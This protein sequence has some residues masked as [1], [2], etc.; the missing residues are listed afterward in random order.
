MTSLSQLL[1][2]PATRRGWSVVLCALACACRSSTGPAAGGHPEGVLV[3]T[4]AVASRPFA[5]AISSGGVVYAGRQDLP[6][7]QVATTDGLTFGDS[8]RVGADPTDIA[9]SSDGT[10]AYVT[11]QFS[12]N[13]G[14]VNVAAHA[15]TDSI[16][17]PANPFRILVAP[18][19]GRIYVSTNNDSLYEIDPVAKTLTRRW[20]FKAPCNGLTITGSGAE[21]FTTTIGG[22]LARLRLATGALDTVTIGGTLQDVALSRD[23]SELFIANESGPLLVRSAATLSA[24]TTVPAVTGAFALKLSP[25][26]TR[27]FTTSTGAG[28]LSI[29]DPSSRAV[30]GSLFLGGLPRR[31]AFSPDGGTALIANEAGFI[32]VIK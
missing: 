8:I 7:V 12:A 17:L 31:I 24:V 11:N 10:T 26:G 32:E 15:S 20:G 4:P 13:V 3:A 21:M 22:Q 19:N 28:F 16:A 23:E 27:L 6:Y 14:I 25:D 5:L 9:F 2:G 29:V 30:V 18:G 1:L